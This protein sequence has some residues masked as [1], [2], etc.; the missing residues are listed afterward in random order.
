MMKR[1]YDKTVMNT[2]FENA[3]SGAVVLNVELPILYILQASDDL[4]PGGTW[5][6][7]WPAPYSHVYPV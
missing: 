4:F 7:S 5:F 3:N 1:V 6:E 2:T